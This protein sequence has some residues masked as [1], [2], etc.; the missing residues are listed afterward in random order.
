MRF[1]AG[2]FEVPE[3]KRN[4]KGRHGK[5]KYSTPFHNF[6]E[7]DKPTLKFSFDTEKD[8]LSCYSAISRIIRAWKL[9]VKVFKRKCEVYCIKGD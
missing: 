3:C 5:G 2:N 8:T 6:M 1:E 9:N 7:G 4:I